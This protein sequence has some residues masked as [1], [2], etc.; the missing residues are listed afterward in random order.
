MSCISIVI[1]MYNEARHIARTLLA[2]QHAA[3][4]RR[5]GMRVDRGRQRLD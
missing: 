5:R 3:D 4:T 2:A 1:P